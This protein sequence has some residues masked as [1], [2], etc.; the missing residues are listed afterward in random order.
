MVDSSVVLWGQAIVY[1]LYAGAVLLVMGVFAYKITRTGSSRVPTVFFTAWAIILVVTGVS[2]HLVTANTI[3]WVATDLD[4]D[5]ITP[6]R[7]FSIEVSDHEFHLPAEKLA[8][9][10][11]ENVLFSV[12]SGDLTYGFGLF[13]PDNSM[14]F[15]MQVVPGHDN[16]VIW[17]FEKNG[18]YDI[19][20][21]EYSGPEGFQMIV[22]EAVVVTGCE[23]TAWTGLGVN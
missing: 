22:P 3:P 1:T 18:V 2:L 19:R 10:C 6:D 12:T 4:R 17:L 23:P 20:S 16:D 8:I 5:S 21:T 15:Q 13:R 9:S 14:V 11:D 7:S